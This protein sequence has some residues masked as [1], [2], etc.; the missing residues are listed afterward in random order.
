MNVAYKSDLKTNT[1]RIFSDTCAF[2]H[3]SDDK[4]I[5]GRFGKTGWKGDNKIILQDCS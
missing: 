1:G 3:T 2:L 5:C 4:C